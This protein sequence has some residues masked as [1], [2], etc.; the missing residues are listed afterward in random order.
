[1]L[2]Y[3][4]GDGS[5][6]P[7]PIFFLLCF[8][9]LHTSIRSGRNNYRCHHHHLGGQAN[10][11]P[12]TDRAAIFYCPAYTVWSESKSRNK[13]VTVTICREIGACISQHACRAQTQSE[14]SSISQK[15]IPRTRKVNSFGS[16]SLTLIPSCSMSREID[17]HVRTRCKASRG[18]REG[19]R[20]LNIKTLTSQ[21]PQSRCAE[22][23][24]RHLLPGVRSEY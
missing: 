3:Q 13:R 8:L 16:L 22:R 17:G 23:L 10:H 20:S 2:I 9:R 11:L 15:W 12:P 18:L 14:A 6:C 24:L 21:S 1:M 7:F 19:Q 5:G 4:N